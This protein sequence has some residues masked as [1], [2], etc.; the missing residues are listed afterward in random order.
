[1]KVSLQMASVQYVHTQRFQAEVVAF[2][3][4]FTQLQDVLGRQRAAVEGQAV[5]RRRRHRHQT[6]E[7]LR[8]SPEPVDAV[9]QVREHPQRASRV[10]LDI[11]AGAPVILVPE[12]SSSPRLVVANLGQ[13]RVQNR[14]LSAGAH[15]TF[16][17]KD[18]VEKLTMAHAFFPSL[19]SHASLALSALTPQ[20]YLLINPLNQLKHLN[21]QCSLLVHKSK[22]NILE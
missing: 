15:G 11:E 13:L 19:V 9:L 6:P 3:Q 5:S 10:L 8:R 17:L 14:F 16:S 7:R 21:D 18:K 1:M 4:H 22:S 2:V 20:L 12:S